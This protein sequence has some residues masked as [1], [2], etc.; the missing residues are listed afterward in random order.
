MAQGGRV[1]TATVV[2][3][4][5]GYFVDVY[6]LLLFSIVRVPSLRELGVSDADMLSTGVLLLNVQMAGLLLGGIVWGILGDKRG[7]VSVLFGSIAL[8]SLAN[9]VNAFVSTVPQ[10]AALRFLAG[11]G[12]AGELGAAVTLVSESLSKEHRGYGTAIVASF[13]LLGA[14]VAALVGGLTGWRVAFLIGGGLGLLL[15]L[16]R[17]G[18]RD[19][20]MFASA[21]ASQAPR[22]SLRRLLSTRERRWR[23]LHSILLGMPI[24]F[25]I[26]V[27]VTFAPEFGLELGVTGALSAGTAVLVSYAGGVVGDF[28]SGFASQRF[29]SRQWIMLV[30]I[31]GIA[32]AIDLI[33]LQ[34]GYSPTAFYAMCAILGF[35]VGYWAVFVTNAAEQFGTNLRSTVAT[36]VPNL[37]RGSVV[38]LTLLVTALRGPLGLGRAAL[39]VGSA[40]CLVA[41][42]SL[43]SLPETYG[44]D[45][46]FVET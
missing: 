26:G 31:A 10:Y 19:S 33:L 5:L 9:I 30:F 1:L 42:W 8:Y 14:V 12:L 17:F 23:Y 35:F 28:A 4:A 21:R 41:L 20:T 39:L 15:L 2:V 25:A 34:R 32:L 45:L 27:L 22:G 6:D 3:S 7:R 40:C 16:M 11:L 29:R 44:R 37:V 46:D 13:G 24:W 38:P 18:L 36:S 43:R